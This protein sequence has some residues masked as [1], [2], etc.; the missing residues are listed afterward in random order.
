[1]SSTSAPESAGFH[2]ILS[3][4]PSWWSFPEHGDSDSMTSPFH[5]NL[6]MSESLTIHETQFENL[7]VRIMEN[8]IDTGV[9]T[10]QSQIIGD[11]IAM[12][13]KELFDH[14]VSVI[15]GLLQFQKNAHDNWEWSQ[16]G[17]HRRFRMDLPESLPRDG[18]AAI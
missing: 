3:P 8:L 13:D 16:E 2:T 15:E 1:M 18:S 9:I 10:L 12:N 11:R 4:I 6:P 5:R 17:T 14:G 7:S